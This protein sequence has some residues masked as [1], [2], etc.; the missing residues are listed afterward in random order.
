MP[1]QTAVCQWYGMLVAHE[2][3]LG[4]VI[5]SLSLPLSVR[6]CH[7]ELIATNTVRS[8]LHTTSGW[9]QT[10]LSSDG[11]AE[12]STATGPFQEATSTC[13]IGSL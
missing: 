2:A 12:S 1:M 10:A 6:C 5:P 8:R 4:A 13:E 9:M 3:E 7:E 11:G